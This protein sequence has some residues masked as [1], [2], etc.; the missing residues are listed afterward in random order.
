VTF[1]SIVIESVDHKCVGSKELLE[2][3]L[4]HQVFGCNI[5]LY[6]LI[7]MYFSF[8][9]ESY[10][11]ILLRHSGDCHDAETRTPTVSS[12]DAIHVAETARELRC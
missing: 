10:L 6:Y 11:S 5:S 2:G 1:R 3:T 12:Q 7:Q 9:Y 4:R 8:L